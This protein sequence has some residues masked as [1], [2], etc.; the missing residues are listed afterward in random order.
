MNELDNK[1]TILPLFANPLMK[2]QL[3]L[4]L[5]KLSEF[6]FE[7]W[8]KDNNGI[9]KTN[10]GGWHSKNIYEEEHEEFIRLKKEISQYLQ[11]YHLEVFQEEDCKENVIQNLHTMWV[12]I[13]EK[14]HYNEWHIHVYST[15]SGVFYIKH[16]GG[17]E[18][19]AI[20]FKNPV[21]SYMTCS[22]WPE[23]LVEQTKAV[24]TSEVIS[25]IP[26]SNML[27]IFPSWLEHK[28]ET[29]LKNDSRISLS[30]NSTPSLE[31]KS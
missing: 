5:E 28:V 27:F 20:Q 29:N 18:N 1:T 21:G 9:Q 22:H 6:A 3:D 4:D 12:N 24:V 7:I 26:K 30:F 19:G 16:G 25:I 15:L 13:N 31:K 17:N 2:I 8:N 23:G 14:H 10:R 11:T